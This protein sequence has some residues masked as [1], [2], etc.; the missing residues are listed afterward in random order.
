M[1][2]R[3]TARASRV[4]PLP[5]ALPPPS[6]PTRHTGLGTCRIACPKR[7]PSVEYTGLFL[8]HLASERRAAW[9]RR[10]HSPVTIRALIAS[11]VSLAHAIETWCFPPGEAESLEAFK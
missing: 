4:Q 5:S 11:E 3:P 7:R 8:E 9:P 10:M 6:S 1:G 2:A